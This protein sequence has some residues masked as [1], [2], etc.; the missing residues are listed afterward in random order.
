[1]KREHLSFLTDLLRERAGQV[2]PLDRLYVVESRLAPLARREGFASVAALLDAL[3]AATEP[4][5]AQAA[6]EALVDPETSFFRDHEPFDRLRDMLLPALARARPGRPLRLWSAG[7]GTGQEAVS[8]AITAL[9]AQ[10][11]TPGLQAEIVATDFADHQLPGRPD[12]ALTAAA[13]E[14]V[15]DA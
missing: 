3:R 9:Q 14:P 2:L 1:M 10:A 12:E 13:A 11:A 15:E 4:R 7:C 5:L 8:L 6:A